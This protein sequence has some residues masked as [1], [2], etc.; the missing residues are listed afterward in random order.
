LPST[1]LSLRPA[2]ERLL[3]QLSHTPFA[4]SVFL[5]DA[6]EQQSPG[7]A[8]DAANDQSNNAQRGGSFFVD[9]LELQRA[10]CELQEPEH[11]ELAM[12][13]IHVYDALA[14]LPQAQRYAPYDQCRFARVC[15]AFN[16]QTSHKHVLEAGFFAPLSTI[17]RPI[18]HIISKAINIRCQARKFPTVVL[19]DIKG[20]SAN[21]RSLAVQLGELLGISL[22]G[23]YPHIPAAERLQGPCRRLV[24]DAL[25]AYR[26]VQ[27][28]HWMLDVL[29]GCNFL[30]INALR[31]LLVHSIRTDPSMQAHLSKLMHLDM[32]ERIVGEHMSRV[33]RYF[34]D[35]LQHESSC[36][37]LT[38]QRA[39]S[40]ERDPK[41]YADA[42]SRVCLDL[43]LL[44]ASSH[45]RI[46]KASF[47]RP[48]Q[49][50]F[51]FPPTLQKKH[52][53][54]PLDDFSAE[55]VH[56]ARLQEEF[57]KKRRQ[58][59]QLI[60]AKACGGLMQSMQSLHASDTTE[61]HTSEDMENIFQF[62]SPQQYEALCELIT[63][64]DPLRSGIVFRVLPELVHFGVEPHA[65][66]FAV[67]QMA[68]YRDNTT[69][70][71][72]LK[73]KFKTMRQFHPHCYNLVQIMCGVVR[74]AHKHWQL[75]QLPL[76]ITRH[77]IE[78]CAQRLRITREI[79]RL[80][81]T[82]G[83]NTKLVDSTIHFVVCRVCNT[84]YSMLHEFAA[85]YK[86]T[87]KF[88]LRDVSLEYCSNEIYCFKSK[89]NHRGRCSDQPLQQ[90]S[91]LGRALVWN[92]RLIMLC[93][94]EGCGNPMTVDNELC[95][96]T[97]RGPCCKPCT[98]ARIKRPAKLLELET[99]YDA[100]LV[101]D[102]MRCAMCQKKLDRL[103]EAICL[104]K[105]LS[106][107]SVCARPHVLTSVRNLSKTHPVASH[108]Q[109]MH[110]ISSN[111]QLHYDSNKRWRDDKSRKSIAS[112]KMQRSR[113]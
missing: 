69:S 33:R 106:L 1:Q 4:L 54:V 93:P 19:K 20:D 61:K 17:K 84:I 13:C 90:I 94:Q 29:K 46:L 55:Q 15:T 71:E 112:A 85:V 63:R 62:V 97:S 26:A 88:C 8:R 41:A 72:Q 104:S 32:F 76:S 25:G 43:N 2:P 99:L 79:A 60:Q 31:E 86:N 40:H 34:Q 21:A 83:E 89:A 53:M 102:K 100:K 18:T 75:F 45:M 16:M 35:M 105:N 49:H 23:N 59:M 7:P 57:N 91:L 24:S 74:Q 12:D 68:H 28:S 27:G 92:Q 56:S 51:Q 77:Q 80:S 37:T 3:A 11:Q 103:H 110:A 58:Q 96:F 111:V 78:S 73:L 52:P 36:L 5:A 66:R 67:E 39:A 113:A 42:M 98:E 9:R 48:N 70:V 64:H 101:E 30:L 38:L 14:H 44:L 10:A 95:D 87:Y 108:A 65:C 22:L 6:L 82:P 50:E 107:C 109:I 81:A 47:R